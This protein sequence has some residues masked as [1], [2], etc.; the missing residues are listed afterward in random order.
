VQRKIIGKKHM[1]DG[2]AISRRHCLASFPNI[3]GMVADLAMKAQGR[4]LN[5]MRGSMVLR[6]TNRQ[7]AATITYLRHVSHNLSYMV[8]CDTCEERVTF[9]VNADTTCYAALC[10]RGK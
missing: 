10:L 1:H 8:H 9:A 3:A 4:C 2:L 7:T 6:G 5:T